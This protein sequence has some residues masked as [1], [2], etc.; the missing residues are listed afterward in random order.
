MDQARAAQEIQERRDVMADG[1]LGM[2]AGT[3]D[4]LKMPLL[5]EITAL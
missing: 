4:N 3:S 5:F 2:S 1:Y